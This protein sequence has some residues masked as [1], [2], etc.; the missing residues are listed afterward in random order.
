M[1]RYSDPTIKWET[2][3]KTNIALELGLFSEL[4]FIAEYYTERR[5]NILQER[6]SIPASMGL[7][8]NPSSNLGK[9]KGHGVDLSLDY[10][11]YFA[12]KSWLQL[13]ANFTYAKSEYTAYEDYEYP[14]AWWK[15]KVGYSMGQQWGYIAEGLFVDD[16]EVKNSPTQFGEYGAG[17]IKYRDVNKDGVINELDQVPI[18]YPTNPEIV[19]GFGASYGYKNWDVS[20]FFQGLARESF[21]IDY[22]AVSPFFDTVGKDFL[23]TERVGN[24]ALAQFIVD[25]YWSEDNRDTY[26]VWPK[27][28]PTSVENNAKRNTWLMRDG[29]FLRLKQ[30][31]FG[32]TI[33]EGITNK[34]NI[35][36]LRFYLNGTNLLCFSKFKL[37]DPE[38]AGNGL[39][40][41]IQRVFNVGL[42]LTF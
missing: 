16:A 24:N 9:A 15:Q 14:G 34:A 39:G 23:E 29:S 17:D 12:N 6:A 21:W 13:R 8:V 32:Y 26:A 1:R 25:S 28:S 41:P 40:Y 10:N 35:K 3:T 30:L 33:P 18:G 4:N 37:W 19:Y 5:K 27:L 42:N 2:A 31:E 20:I 22:N 38:M 36:N 7:W 11:K